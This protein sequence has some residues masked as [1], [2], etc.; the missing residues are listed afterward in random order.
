[1]H[2]RPDDLHSKLFV[3]PCTQHSV[4]TFI[5]CTWYIFCHSVCHCGEHNGDGDESQDDESPIIA[6]YVMTS[7]HNAMPITE[8]NQIPTEINCER[9][10]LIILRYRRQM[11]QL[12]AY[13]KST[14]HHT[15]HTTQVNRHTN[16]LQTDYFAAIYC[17]NSI[18]SITTIIAHCDF[19]LFSVFAAPLNFKR[20]SFCVFCAVTMTYANGNKLRMKICWRRAWERDRGEDGER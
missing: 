4:W 6:F 12:I 17:L 2:I 9:H 5:V 3:D 20:F 1:M 19:D 10:K 8:L 15:P 13:P 16:K 11:P 14:T 7:I 18:S